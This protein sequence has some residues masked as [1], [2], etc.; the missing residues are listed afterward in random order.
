MPEVIEI[1]NLKLNFFLFYFLNIDFSFTFNGIVL[2]FAVCL[3]KVCFERKMSQILCLGFSLYFM[4]KTLWHFFKCKLLRFI[5]YKQGT[6]S[7]F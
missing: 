5:K 7:K 1:M 3:Q 4:S 6:K 2:K